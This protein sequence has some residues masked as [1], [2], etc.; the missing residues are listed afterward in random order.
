[1]LLCWRSAPPDDGPADQGCTGTDH[2]YRDPAAEHLAR[3][4]L[5]T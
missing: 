4:M 1:V 3:M 2:P 5:A